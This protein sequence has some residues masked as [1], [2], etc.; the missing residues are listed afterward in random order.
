M[1]LPPSH[2]ARFPT[3]HWSLVEHLGD[4]SGD[5]AKRE[6]LGELLNRYR[7]PLRACLLSRLNVDTHTADDLVQGFIAASIL[8]KQLISRADRKVGKFRGFLVASLMNYA[9]SRFRDDSALKRAPGKLLSI[10]RIADPVDPSIE[11]GHALDLEWAREVLRQAA[12]MMR[13]GCMED[14][15]GHL[16]GVF[17]ARI[18]RPAM[19]RIEPMPYEEIVKRFRFISPSQASNALVTANRKF[20]RCLRQVVGEYEFGTADI[21]VEIRDLWNI[22]SKGRAGFR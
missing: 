19:D 5:D 18:L 13:D 20:I 8:E 17:E 16:W 3:T 6:A 1:S 2:P 10:D 21:D 12:Q 7:H 15:R 22:F 14:G 4:K 11:P 9:A